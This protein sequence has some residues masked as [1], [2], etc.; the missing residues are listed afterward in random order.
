MQVGRQVLHGGAFEGQ[1][2]ELT[3]TGGAIFYGG[4]GACSPERFERLLFMHFEGCAL[5]ELSVSCR[6][7]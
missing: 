6:E 4:Q 5:F 2:C 3:S 7:Q 1:G